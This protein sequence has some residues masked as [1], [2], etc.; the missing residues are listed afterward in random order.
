MSLLVDSTKRGFS[1]YATFSGRASRAETWW[2]WFAVTF[3]SFVL[4]IVD[5]VIGMAD[6]SPLS[7]IFSLATLIPC[8]AVGCRR[9]H[10]IGKSGWFQLLWFIPIIGWIV[11]LIWMCTK[12][13]EG[14]N[15]FGPMPNLIEQRRRDWL[16]PVIFTIG[17][18]FIF[19]I[20]VGGM[21][22][23]TEAVEKAEARKAAQ[24]SVSIPVTAAPA[25]APV[26]AGVAPATPIVAPETSG[27]APA[28]PVSGGVALAAPVTP[29]MPTEAPVAPVAPI[30][31]PTA[32][33]PAPVSAAAPMDACEQRMADHAVKNGAD[34]KAYI[35]QNQA[36][37]VQCRQS[38]GAAQ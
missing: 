34:P 14:D 29:A 27:M 35:A 19:G 10:D 9:L 30:A 11:L 5:I 6:I 16:L 15:R 12:G 13:Q 8:I 38:A 28:A 17:V 1:N 3:I 37:L 20:F 24:E 23:A 18:P 32:V 26:P 36:Y 7:S 22:V 2:F 33:A 25:E 21:A 4:S 31:A